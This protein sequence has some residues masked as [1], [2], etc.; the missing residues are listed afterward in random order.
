MT[1]DV[2]PLVVGI[3]ASDLAAR[4]ADRGQHVR[5][6]H[7]RRNGRSSNVTALQEFLDP[8]TAREMRVVSDS[9]PARG[10]QAIAE[11]IVK[12]LRL[13]G[14]HTA[15]EECSSSWPTTWTPPRERP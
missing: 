7:V 14:A 4:L 13:A 8:A 10:L 9:S 11:E 5:L 6:I 15:K 2:P 3:D 12:Q 1:P